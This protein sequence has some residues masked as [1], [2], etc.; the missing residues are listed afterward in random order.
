MNGN[1]VERFDPDEF[2]KLVNEPCRKENFRGCALCTVRTD[3]LKLLAGRNDARLPASRA[4]RR[5]CSGRVLQGLIQKLRQGPP[6]PSEQ[7]VNR[8]RAQIALTAFIAE[9]RF[10]VAPSQ[11]ECGA[12]SRRPAADNENIELHRKPFRCLGI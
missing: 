9:Q 12:E 11:D 5:I 4:P 2:G 3:K 10:P 7:A 1:P 6:F 8:V